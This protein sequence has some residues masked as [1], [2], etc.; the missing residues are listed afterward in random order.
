MVNH[1]EKQT[2]TVSLVPIGIVLTKSCF[3]SVATTALHHRVCMDMKP[4]DS[5]AC[6]RPLTGGM[7]TRVGRYVP[8]IACR[9]HPEWLDVG[10]NYCIVRSLAL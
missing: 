1:P 5:L 3:R 8:E 4:D 6:R 2:D 9:C 7:H 10:T